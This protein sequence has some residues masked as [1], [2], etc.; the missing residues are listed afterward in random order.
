[1]VSHVIF[2]FDM[3]HWSKGRRVLARSRGDLG[4]SGRIRVVRWSCGWWSKGD[5][6]W[7]GR[8]GGEGILEGEGEGGSVAGVSGRQ[9]GRC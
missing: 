4:S 9:R 8:G 6:L 1:M 5:G 2:R 7:E 3:C